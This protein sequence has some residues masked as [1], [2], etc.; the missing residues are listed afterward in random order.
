MPKKE[1][2]TKGGRDKSLKKLKRLESYC[3][4]DQW[5]LVSWEVKEIADAARNSGLKF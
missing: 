3:R 2:A 1:Q 4:F 5:I